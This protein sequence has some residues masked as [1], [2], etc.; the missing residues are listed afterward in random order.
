MTYTI[1]VCREGKEDLVFKGVRDY[2][3]DP[4][5][6]KIEIEPGRWGSVWQTVEGIKGVILHEEANNGNRD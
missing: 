2:S 1:I 4:G 5:R 6:I 3:A